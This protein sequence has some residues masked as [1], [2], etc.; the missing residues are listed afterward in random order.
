MFMKMIEIF[1]R[2]HIKVDLNGLTFMTRTPLKFG[3]CLH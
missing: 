2:K 3:T 1:N